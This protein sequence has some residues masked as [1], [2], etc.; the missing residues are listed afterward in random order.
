MSQ[1]LREITDWIDLMV[2]FKASQKDMKLPIVVHVTFQ[3]G[4]FIILRRVGLYLLVQCYSGVHGLKS[5][6]ARNKKIFF[7][8]PTRTAD[9]AVRGS[10][11]TDDS[12]FSVDFSFF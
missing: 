3:I 9:L 7:G 4:F 2:K 11:V 1:N 8:Q 6:S 5:W 10:L 12:P